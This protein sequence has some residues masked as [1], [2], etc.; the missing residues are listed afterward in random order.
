MSRHSVTTFLRAVRRRLWLDSL[1]RQMRLAAWASS[2]TFLLL[3][4]LRFA[5]GEPGFSFAIVTATAVGL[6]ALLPVLGARASLAECALR[7][8]R[9]FGGHSLVTTAHELQQVSNPRP[10]EEIVLTRATIAT[11]DW[12]RRLNTLW[13]TPDGVSYLPAV[14]PV[15]IAALI[16]E[17][18]QDKE[19][20]ISMLDGQSSIAV[21]SA[22]QTDIFSKGSDLPELREAIARTAMEGPESSRQ[23]AVAPEDAPP[24]PVDAAPEPEAESLEAI[25]S[26]ALPAGFASINNS[27]G[28]SPGDARRRAGETE[29]RQDDSGPLF[30][31]QIEIEIARHGTTGAGRNDG[32]DEFGADSQGSHMRN[33][34]IVPAP[35]S[36]A[37][38]A[39]TTLTAAELAYARKYL[40]AAG[41]HN[42]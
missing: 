24:I 23:D 30:S 3:A 34:K 4:L 25:E 21:S 36:P 20:Q 41:F 40:D 6:I 26:D 39:W 29:S 9:V 1:L 28:R 2:G 33:L 37:S 13:K 42:E 38:S 18:P 32:G 5:G 7:S 19:E 16:F 31:E 17:L 10:T 12:R 22:G 14:I 35:A 15:F 27:D 8:D 11:A